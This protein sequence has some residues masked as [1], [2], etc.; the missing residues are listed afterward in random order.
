MSVVGWSCGAAALQCALHISAFDSGWRER[1]HIADYTVNRSQSRQS[2]A[3]HGGMLW[4]SGK[5]YQRSRHNV[6]SPL[7]EA[8]NCSRR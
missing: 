4:P 8:S 6:S 1:L 5:A 2:Q 7:I 3:V